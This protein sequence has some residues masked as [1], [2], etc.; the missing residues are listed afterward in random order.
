MVTPTQAHKQMKNN[1]I[2]IVDYQENNNMMVPDYLKDGFY[3]EKVKVPVTT[4]NNTINKSSEG[5]TPQNLLQL[6]DISQLKLVEDAWA[7]QTLI[8]VV[9]TFKMTEEVSKMKMLSPTSANF[10]NYVGIHNSKLK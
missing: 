1:N 6:E 4:E 8:D 2:Q 3:L 7:D 10:S 9:A 5:N